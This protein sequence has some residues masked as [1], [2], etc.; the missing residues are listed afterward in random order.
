MGVGVGCRK[1]GRGSGCRK[2]GRGR[3]YHMGVGMGWTFKLLSTTKANYQERPAHHKTQYTKRPAPAKP[4]PPPPGRARP[5]PALAQADEVQ[6]DAGTPNHGMQGRRQ[7]RRR[8]QGG[9]REPRKPRGGTARRKSAGAP[10]LPRYAVAA[11]DRAEARARDAAPGRQRQ[12]GGRVKDGGRGG[13]KKEKKGGRGTARKTGSGESGSEN[14]GQNGGGGRAETAKREPSQVGGRGERAQRTGRR[15]QLNGGA[16]DVQRPHRQRREE[17]WWGPTGRPHTALE[18]RGAG[19]ARLVEGCRCRAR[20][21]H[22]KGAR[23][24]S[25]SLPE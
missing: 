6:T 18:P 20:P 15:I 8:P 12:R 10:A 22:A 7:K 13:G 2:M 16:R 24:A 19:T 4:R 14:K 3:G 23:G 17:R 25:L 21:A 1:M 9:A 11:R 5:P